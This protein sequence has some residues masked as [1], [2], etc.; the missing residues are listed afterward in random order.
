MQRQQVLKYRFDDSL[1]TKNDTFKIKTVIKNI[2]CLC[3]FA[4]INDRND[5]F[6]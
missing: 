3:G 4:G 5:T 6:F 1:M 2:Q